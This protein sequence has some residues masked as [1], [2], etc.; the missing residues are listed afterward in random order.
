MEKFD[1]GTMDCGVNAWT[2]NGKLS[3]ARSAFSR[4]LQGKQVSEKGI[5]KALVG[6]TVWESGWGYGK[7]E[8]TKVEFL[9]FYKLKGLAK[10]RISNDGNLSAHVYVRW[11]PTAVI[12]SETKCKAKHSEADYEALLARVAILEE[13]VAK[14]LA[15]QGGI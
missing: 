13:T 10:V 7:R 6:L 2:N 3:S 4:R 12:K 14:L 9:A 5:E 1:Y 15:K 8:I 11:D